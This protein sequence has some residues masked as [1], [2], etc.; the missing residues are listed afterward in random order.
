MTRFIETTNA[1]ANEDASHSLN[2]HHRRNSQG[3]K[4]ESPFHYLVGDCLT[5]RV[6][7]GT[8]LALFQWRDEL[9]LDIN[10]MRNQF[11]KDSPLQHSSNEPHE[12][13]A[14]KNLHSNQQLDYSAR[15]C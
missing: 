3:H 4:R 13:I 1:A 12:C 11:A 8:G 10:L 5:L 9:C 7:R 15:Y 6:L 14:I 2:L